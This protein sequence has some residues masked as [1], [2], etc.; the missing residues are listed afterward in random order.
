MKFNVDLCVQ[1]RTRQKETIPDI[2]TFGKGMTSGYPS[3][4]DY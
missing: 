3:A 2:M 4:G 1:E